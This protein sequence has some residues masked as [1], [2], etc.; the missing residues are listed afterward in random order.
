MAAE[1]AEV[2]H[3]WRRAERLLTLLPADAP[4][5][6]EVE[7]HVQQ[8]RALYQ[9]VT[10][11]SSAPSESRLEAI[12]LQLERSSAYLDGLEMRYD[13]RDAVALGEAIPG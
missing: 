1:A 5:R 3:E 12:R 2:L 9:R 4:E 10:V 11:E 6:P 8:L 7:D 13:P